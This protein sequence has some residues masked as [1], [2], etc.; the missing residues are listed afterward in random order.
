MAIY[1]LAAAELRQI[2]EGLERQASLLERR[3]AR[4]RSVWF[5]ELERIRA[6]VHSAERQV[7]CQQSGHWL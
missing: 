1:T 2:L 6:K 4:N 5:D 7:N 3:L